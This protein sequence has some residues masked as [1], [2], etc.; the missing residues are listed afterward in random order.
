MIKY[1]LAALLTLGGLTTLASA[2]DPADPAATPARQRGGQN[3][4]DQLA[5]T[6]KLT[7]EQKTKMG[8]VLKKQ[9]EKMRELRQDTALS[10]EDRRAKMT[11]IQ[12]EFD[13][14]IKKI[15]TTEQYDQYKKILEQ[16][17]QGGNR[18]PRP[19]Q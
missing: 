11:K 1:V 9:G 19:A 14:E 2:A 18:G 4:I 17:R 16:R 15:L 8:D 3:N 13:P 6:L 5:K 12:E 10:R 7:D